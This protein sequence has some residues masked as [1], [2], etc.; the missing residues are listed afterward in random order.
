MR[1]V[2]GWVGHSTCSRILDRHP[3]RQIESVARLLGGEGLIVGGWLVG[4]V[5]V[6]VYGP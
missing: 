5:W 3:R 6:A 2:W 1:F 4:L